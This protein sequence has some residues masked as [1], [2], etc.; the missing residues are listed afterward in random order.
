MSYSYISFKY[1]LVRREEYNLLKEFNINKAT[2]VPSSDSLI[3]IQNSNVEYL[4]FINLHHLTNLE[5]E[6]VL[7]KNVAVHHLIE[8]LK[9]SPQAIFLDKFITKYSNRTHIGNY[10]DYKL[11]KNKTNKIITKYCI[12]NYKWYLPEE[13]AVEYLTSLFY[14]TKKPSLTDLS[15]LNYN[16]HTI[17][18]KVVYF[19]IQ[20]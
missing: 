16:G 10:P 7:N 18:W 3:N 14:L 19:K 15:L 8:I 12:K 1:P 20:Q 11:I 9:G 17:D 4:S 5:L 6:K 13:I 2:Q